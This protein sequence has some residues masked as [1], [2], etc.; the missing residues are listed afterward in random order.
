MK[1]SVIQD[2]FGV[3]TVAF[4]QDVDQPGVVVHPLRM[5]GPG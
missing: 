4:S 1:K 2:D 5:P 3:H